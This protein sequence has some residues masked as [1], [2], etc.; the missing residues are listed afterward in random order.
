LGF[1]F[2]RKRADKN[3]P[4]ETRRRLGGYDFVKEAN[5]KRKKKRERSPYYD[6]PYKYRLDIWSCL[7]LIQCSLRSSSVS[8]DHILLPRSAPETAHPQGIP[9][10]RL[11]I[12]RDLDKAD[13]GWEAGLESSSV[14]RRAVG[15]RPN[16][17][18]GDSSLGT[19]RQYR[20]VFVQ[21]LLQSKPQ[22][23]LS[24]LVLV[25]LI[26]LCPSPGGKR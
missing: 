8:R 2:Q 25:S 17:S 7:R 9:N 14:I 16:R 10:Q 11:K 22:H 5:S 6:W 13:S 15:S 12:T 24:K 4:Y 1:F 20:V 3:G 23:P 18:M 21:P 19:G 26:R